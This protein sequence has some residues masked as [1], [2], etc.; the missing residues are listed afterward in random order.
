M[1]FFPPLFNVVKMYL[2][3]NKTIFA[4]AGV[5]SSELKDRTKLAQMLR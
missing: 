4:P 1:L 2:P 3:F 5:N